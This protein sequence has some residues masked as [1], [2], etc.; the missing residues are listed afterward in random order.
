M[1]RDV[2]LSLALV[3]R[4]CVTLSCSPYLSEPCF[5]ICTMS[6]IIKTH[7]TGVFSNLKFP[8]PYFFP[9]SQ[10]RGGKGCGVLTPDFR[11]GKAW[12]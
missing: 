6:R 8:V 12:S 5:F 1:G 11:A 3:I 2:V 9:F 4:G 10:D 7:P